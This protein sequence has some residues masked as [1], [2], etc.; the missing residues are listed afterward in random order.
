MS[1]ASPARRVSG[2]SK[3][4][5]SLDYAAS[6]LFDFSLY[7][8]LP[9]SRPRFFFLCFSTLR[10]LDFFALSLSR[11]LDFSSFRFSAVSMSLLL[12]FSSSRLC[13]F[14][15]SRVVDLSIA[16]FAG[17]LARIHTYARTRAR[18]S[19][20]TH[21]RPRTQKLA[22]QTQSQAQ[23]QAPNQTPRQTQT[24]T[25]RRTQTHARTKTQTQTQ[26]RAEARRS[27]R[28]LSSCGAGDV[29][30]FRGRASGR[31]ERRPAARSTKLFNSERQIIRKRERYLL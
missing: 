17:E 25:R 27:Q 30:R 29:R 8:F 20:D 16:R 24:Q 2:A 28:A 3:V 31:L 14:S 22:P 18:Q 19:A 11:R 12:A 15:V 5:R 7:R 10:L 6:C 23:S 9:F 4:S 1:R 21:T 13:G 26:A